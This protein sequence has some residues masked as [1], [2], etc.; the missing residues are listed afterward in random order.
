MDFRDHMD[1]QE[2]S[3]DDLMDVL[4][5]TQGLEKSISSVLDGNSRNLSLSALMSASINGIISQCATLDEVVL[6]RNIF[7]QMFDKSIKGIRINGPI[8]PCDPQ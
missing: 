6:Y 2:I 5:M 3:H 4:E 7:I 1:D 8:P